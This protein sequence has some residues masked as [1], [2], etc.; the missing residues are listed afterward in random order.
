MTLQP[1]SFKTNPNL[2]KIKEKYHL[3]NFMDLIKPG[4]E[5]GFGIAAINIRSKYILK[6]VL[7]SAWE[8][9]SPIILEIAVSESQYCN[10]SYKRLSQWTVEEMER[11]YDEHGYM[12][13][14]CLHADHVKE[15]VFERLEEATKAGFTSF[16]CDQSKKSLDENIKV[17][18]DIVN[19]AH[20]LGISVEGEIG[21]I[22]ASKA[23][24][25]PNLKKNILN[26]VPTLEEAKKL[27]QE[28]GIDAFAGFF[29]NVHGAYS[30]TPI[31]TFDRMKEIYDGLKEAGMQTPLVLHGSS[32]METKEFDHIG[33]F[34][35]ALECGCYKYNY[36]TNI[37]DIF[38][39]YLPDDLVA[40]MSQKAG[41]EDNWRKQLGAYEEKIDALDKKRLDD[42]V[43]AM[44]THMK[45][46]LKN[47]F[48]SAGRLDLYDE[49]IM[50][51]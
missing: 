31:I 5:H 2:K 49:E 36:A 28:A 34:N 17:T 26:Y 18:K 33:V 3:V 29:G 10:I 9:K 48:L 38:K 22:G 7:E 11:L 45:M 24:E 42:S 15:E 1:L 44:K 39:D 21:E 13:P 37:S 25:D 41:S 46:M 6:A 43:V 50:T 16:A 40:E 30:T 20:A 19:K 4:M 32:Y 12:V 8:I 27:V 51:L 47:A 14:V 35:K 23:L